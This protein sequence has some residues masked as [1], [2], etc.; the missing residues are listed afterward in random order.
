MPVSIEF[1]IARRNVVSA[2]SAFWA[3]RRRRVWRQLAISI[4]AVMALSTL[5]SQNRPLPTTPSE[6]RQACARRIR[7][8]P[9]GD[10]GTSSSFTWLAQGIRPMLLL[11]AGIVRPARRLPLLSSS[12]TAYLADS[13][14]GT[15]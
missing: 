14:V 2:T 12:A 1:S 10:T 13:S 7:P 6:V 4:Q 3:C 9:T 8:L 5:T 11:R 15:A